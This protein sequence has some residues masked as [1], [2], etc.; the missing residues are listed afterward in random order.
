VALAANHDR[1]FS[2]KLNFRTISIVN[3]RQ[4]AINLSFVCVEEYI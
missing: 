3:E 2:R 1:Q 4:I